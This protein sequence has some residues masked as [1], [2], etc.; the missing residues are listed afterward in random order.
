MGL[1]PFSF[2]FFARLAAVFAE[3]C[4]PPFSV[5]IVHVMDLKENETEKL[6]TG[7]TWE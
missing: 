6:T 3:E 7:V 1:L 4:S 2:Q 5:S